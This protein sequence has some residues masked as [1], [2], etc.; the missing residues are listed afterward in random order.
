V[1][2]LPVIEEAAAL[3]ADIPQLW[4]EA[5]PEERTKLISPLIEMVHVDI[6]AKRITAFK[7]AP[8]FRALFNAG[9]TIAPNAPIQLIPAADAKV[10][11][12]GV[13]GDGGDAV[14]T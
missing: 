13:G 7:P 14:S 8:A 10:D 11:N 9:I 6:E 12:I 2:T 1:V 5:T 4:S 3:F